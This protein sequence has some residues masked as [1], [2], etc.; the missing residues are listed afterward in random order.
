MAAAVLLSVTL[1]FALMVLFVRGRIVAERKNPI[2]RVLIWLYRP[3]H[4]HADNAAWNIRDEGGG[5]LVAAGS[6]HQIVS[7]GR[8]RLWQGRSSI[9][10]HGPRSTREAFERF[11]DNLGERARAIDLLDPF[12]AAWGRP[13]YNRVGRHGAQSAPDGGATRL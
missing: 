6:D 4:V 12:A 2:N 5:T 3:G 8:V 1:V 10:G 9:D 7:G 11:V 13:P